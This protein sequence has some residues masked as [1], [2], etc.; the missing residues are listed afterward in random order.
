MQV[1]WWRELDLQSGSQRHRHFVGFF[2]LPVKQRHGATFLYGYSETP[3]HLVTFYD[4]L[5]IRRTHS[6]LNPQGKFFVK[7]AVSQKKCEN[8]PNAVSMILDTLPALYLYDIYDM[9]H[10]SC[11]SSI[12]ETLPAL[13]LRGRPLCLCWK[14]YST[15]RKMTTARPT[16]I[17]IRIV[18][19]FISCSSAENNNETQWQHSEECMCRLRNIAMRDY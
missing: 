19:W 17:M 5:G 11:P 3:S 7:N 16:T 2:N 6:R 8:H 13:Y 10:P 4:T 1:D 18:F 9:W 14:Q 12:C 15:I